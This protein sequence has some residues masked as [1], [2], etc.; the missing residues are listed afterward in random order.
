ML[1]NKWTWIVIGIS[2]I[3]TLIVEIV[4]PTNEEKKECYSVISRMVG[5]A[6]NSDGALDGRRGYTLEQVADSPEQAEKC[7]KYIVE[8]TEDNLQ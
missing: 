7:Q 8:F 5:S 3:L 6:R 1:K 4:S 2:V